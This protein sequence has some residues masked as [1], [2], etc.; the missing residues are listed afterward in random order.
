MSVGAVG[1]ITFGYWNR[2]I[3]MI[4]T[5]LCIHSDSVAWKVVLKII[6]PRQLPSWTIYPSHNFCQ[7]KFQIVWW[8]K[9]SEPLRGNSQNVSNCQGWKWSGRWNCCGHL[10]GVTAQVGFVRVELSVLRLCLEV[11]IYCDTNLIRIEFH[12][13]VHNT[14]IH[15]ILC[16]TMDR[17]VYTYCVD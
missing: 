6:L 5:P 12:K 13:F 11:P 2:L 9:L 1:S 15:R 4:W 8:A 16:L 17:Q 3:E 7:G 14:Q 10:V